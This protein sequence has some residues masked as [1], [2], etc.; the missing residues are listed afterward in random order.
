M[1]NKYSERKVT[2]NKWYVNHGWTR[3]N[4]MYSDRHIISKLECYIHEQQTEGH[5]LHV[6]DTWPK[7]V[8]SGNDSADADSNKTST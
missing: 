2:K 4:K 1:V 7:R 5:S 3:T 6:C 8:N